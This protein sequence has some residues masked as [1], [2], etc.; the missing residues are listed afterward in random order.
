MGKLGVRR[1]RAGS[2]IRE[3]VQTCG[4]E[5][6]CCLFPLLGVLFTVPKLILRTAGGLR[7]EAYFVKH[8]RFPSRSSWGHH[9]QPQVP[10][11]G[12]GVSCDAAGGGYPT[13]NDHERSGRQ[14]RGARE[15]RDATSAPILTAGR[16]LHPVPA[17]R[18][19]T[20][21]RTRRRQILPWPSRP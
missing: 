1:L 19:K 8:S 14:N 5:W 18:Q 11:F 17:P 9:A 15:G 12:P 3:N 16:D 21:G 20:G 2:G 13:T 4:R 10:Y 6:G 7:S